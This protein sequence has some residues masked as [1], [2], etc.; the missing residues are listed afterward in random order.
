MATRAKTA[1][2]AEMDAL[3]LARLFHPNTNLAALQSSGPLMLARGKGIH[4]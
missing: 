2:A 1:G 4:V 3:D